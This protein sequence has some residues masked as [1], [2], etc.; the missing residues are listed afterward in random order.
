MKIRIRKQI[1]AKLTTRILVVVFTLFLFLGGYITFKRVG[2]SQDTIPQNINITNITDRS[3]T[4][5]WTTEKPTFGQVQYGTDT[6]QNFLAF[7]IRDLLDQKQGKYTTLH[8]G[9]KYT[10]PFVQ[11]YKVHFVQITN[12]KPQ[13]SYMYQIISE[14]KKYKSTGA[15]TTEA[16]LSTQQEKPQL[17]GIQILDFDS[18]KDEVAIILS[19]QSNTERSSSLASLINSKNTLFNLANLRTTDLAKRFILPS[20]Q[21]TLLM[22]VISSDSVWSNIVSYEP[23]YFWLK[24]IFIHPNSL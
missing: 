10:V 1:P 16:S 21:T 9:Q 24:P 7:D 8:F 11:K 19:S 13:S 22:T 5:I 20:P 17:T 2:A 12:L 3:F 18:K 4:I 6:N 23:S 14:Q 15:V